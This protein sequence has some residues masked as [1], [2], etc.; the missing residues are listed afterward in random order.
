MILEPFMFPLDIYFLCEPTKFRM[1]ARN[2]ESAKPH[3]FRLPYV[4][5]E[6]GIQW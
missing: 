4:W 3:F 5:H 1:Q 6:P 2:L